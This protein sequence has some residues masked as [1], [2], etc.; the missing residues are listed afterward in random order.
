MTSGTSLRNRSTGRARSLERGT[1][2]SPAWLNPYA[3]YDA[4]TGGSSTGIT[5]SSTNARAAM[6]VGAGSN[7]PLWLPYTVP[8]VTIPTAGSITTPDSAAFAF[9]GDQ[10]IR[11]C[12]TVPDWTPAANSPLM[13][14]D[15]GV[16]GGRRFTFYLSSTGKPAL[17]WSTDGTASVA[18]L[19]TVGAGLTDGTVG[20]A[21]V[22]LDVDDGAGNNVVRFYQKAATSLAEILDN[23]GWT[24]LDTVTTAG[25]TSV[26]GVSTDSLRIGASGAVAVNQCGVVAAAY[27]DGINGTAVATFDA[28]LCGQSGYTGSLGNVWSVNRSTTG[29]KPVVQSPSANSANSMFLLGTDDYLLAPA[30]AV[31]P[32]GAGAPWTFVV[33]FRLWATTPSFARVIDSSSTGA[34]T[35]AAGLRVLNSGTATGVQS[36]VADGTTG[37]AQTLN[38]TLGT[39]TVL[40][41]SNTT[42]DSMTSI[43]NGTSSGGSSIAALGSRSSGLAVQVGRSVTGNYNDMEFRTLLT[44]DRALS[45]TEVAQLAGYY[46]GGL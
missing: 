28:A 11:W 42:G 16:A 14:Q 1:S 19:S 3:W 44:F 4:H 31:P 25:T 43:L 21:R 10:D 46:G 45:V 41:T 22:T 18:K 27:L 34:T 37:I 33:V 23:S 9:T 2:W 35:T 26:S 6:T 29:R 32:M 36:K 7:S 8:T 39:R 30:A 40:S 38:C 15:T 24:L 12:G 5:D 13:A 17:I 20:A